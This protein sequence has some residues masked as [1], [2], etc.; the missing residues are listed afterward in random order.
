[1]F[2]LELQL[3]KIIILA[4]VSKLVSK[5][6]FPSRPF[7]FGSL[8][9]HVYHHESCCSLLFACFELWALSLLFTVLNL[10]CDSFTTFRFRVWVWVLGFYLIFENVNGNI[11]SWYPDDAY[12]SPPHHTAS[13]HTIPCHTIVVQTQTQTQ[14]H[15]R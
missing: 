13:Y 11:M 7:A 9:S 3:T 4:V 8:F 6:Y 2:K 15:E 12:P 14:T 5:K 10:Q 1:M